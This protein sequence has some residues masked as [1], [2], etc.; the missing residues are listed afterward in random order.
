MSACVSERAGV[1]E[2]GVSERAGAGISERVGVSERVLVKE[3]V[4][5]RERVDV[6]ER[7]SFKNAPW[8]ASFRDKRHDCRKPITIDILTRLLDALNLICYSV[9]ETCLFKASFS[10]AFF[11]FLRVGEIAKSNFNENHIV[12][13]SNITFGNNSG[14]LYIVV[15]SSKTDQLGNSVTIVLERYKISSICPVQLMSDYIAMRH[16]DDGHLFCHANMKTLTR[17]Q[18]SNILKKTLAFLG[19][20]PSEFNTHSLRIG[21]ATQSFLD[22]LDENSIKLKG[23][24]KSAAYKGYQKDILIIGSSIV[25]RASE[26]AHIRPIGDSLGLEKIG[27]ELVWIGMSGMKWQNLVSLVQSILNWRSIPFSVIIHCGGND[28]GDT[29]CGELL[30]HMKFT[31]A[32]LSKM[33]PD[34]ALVW[35]NILPRYKWRFSNNT[36][37]METARRRINRGMRSYLLKNRRIRYKT[38]RF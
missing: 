34:T 12:K 4:L 19:Y 26:H 13:R 37:A 20:N 23:R 9:Y 8:H 6:S 35:S 38:Y 17:Y 21:A 7:E 25:T 29:P 1:S 16:K 27:C 10:V 14:S 5:V 22:G 3:W 15:P 24:W 30:Y 2:R 33:L 31:I 11:G 36:G 28:I 32:I 18:F